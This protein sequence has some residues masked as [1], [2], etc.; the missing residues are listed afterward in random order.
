MSMFEAAAGGGDSGVEWS[1][2]IQGQDVRL[3]I[4][5]YITVSTPYHPTLPSINILMNNQNN[6]TLKD[7]M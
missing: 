3:P 7:N 6:S 1:G 5:F 4:V 2:G